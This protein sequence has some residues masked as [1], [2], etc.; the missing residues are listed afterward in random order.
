MNTMQLDVLIRT[1]LSPRKLWNAI[2]VWK[3]VRN[4]KFSSPLASPVPI[5]PENVKM[6]QELLARM[7]LGGPDVEEEGEEQEE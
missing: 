7:Y 1:L 2:Q 3:M 5:S 4:F 6:L